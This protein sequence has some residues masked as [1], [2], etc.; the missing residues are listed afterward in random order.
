LLE[1]QE[2]LLAVTGQVGV[3]LYTGTREAVR[4]L[5]CPL[6]GKVGR[7]HNDS[8]MDQSITVDTYYIKG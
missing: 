1:R 3:P 5:K 4:T 8:D 7:S 6:R 2:T